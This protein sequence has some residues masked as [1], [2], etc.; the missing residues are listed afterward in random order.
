MRC[1]EISSVTSLSIYPLTSSFQIVANTPHLI[2]L[3]SG[4][5]ARREDVWVENVLNLV[6]PCPLMFPNSSLLCLVLQRSITDPLS[7]V[8]PPVLCRV[9]ARTCSFRKRRTVSL[10]TEVPHSSTSLSVHIPHTSMTLEGLPHPTYA[11]C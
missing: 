7:C 8:D 3:G 2:R 1:M 5:F 11:E 6:H 4:P 10:P 9:L